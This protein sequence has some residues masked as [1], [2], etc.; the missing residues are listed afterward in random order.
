[1]M[2]KAAPQYLPE[3]L[4]KLSQLYWPADCPHTPYPFAEPSQ[5]SFFASSHTLTQIACVKHPAKAGQQ[6]KLSLIN[7]NWTAL[8]SLRLSSWNGGQCVIK[9]SVL[10]HDKICLIY[11]FAAATLFQDPTVSHHG[12]FLQWQLEGSSLATQNKTSFTKNTNIFVVA[13]PGE[14]RELL[15]LKVTERKRRIRSEGKQKVQKLA[16]KCM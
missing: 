4:H 14:P 1:M 11:L 9:V 6:S 8:K 16:G 12:T 5:N 15:R 2:R 13:T 10:P 3:T 7:P